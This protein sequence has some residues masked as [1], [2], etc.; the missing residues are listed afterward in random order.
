MPEKFF[1]AAL[2]LLASACALAQAPDTARIDFAD[3]LRDAFANSPELRRDIIDSE[4]SSYDIMR[5]R[6]AFLPRVDLQA[7]DDQIYIQGGV[8][9]L[10]ALELSGRTKGD[11]AASSVKV[12][13]N[14]F[15]GG[16][17]VARFWHAREKQAE[18]GLQV[19]QQCAAVAQKVLDLYHA[20]R[21]AGFDLAAA[22][23]T[24]RRADT[25]LSDAKSRFVSGRVSKLELS[26]ANF[27]D[28]EKQLAVAVKRRALDAALQDLH[29]VTDRSAKALPAPV[30][31]EPVAEAQY[32]NALARFGLTQQEIV[33]DI[34]VYESRV[35]QSITD[36]PKARGRFAPSID[37]YWRQSYAGVGSKG[38]LDA[39]DLQS[40]DKRFIGVALTWIL[41][42]GLDAYAD[43]RQ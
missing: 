35:K 18:A 40:K 43:L 19:R 23:V 11:Y 42:E 13:W 33:T 31:S 36:L 22:Q 29:D 7:T 9:S 1:T 30:A 5:A 39:F 28:Q 10:E 6:S 2:A 27:D 17:D 8:A 41:F 4:V 15:N 20:V 21:Q 14:L 12:S 38:Y 34:D 26:E 32:T 25:A 16:Q 37:V 3:S 24:L